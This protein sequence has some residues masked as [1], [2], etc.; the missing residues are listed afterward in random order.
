MRQEVFEL[1]QGMDKN[2]MKTQMALQCAPLITGLKVA[3]LFIVLSE[4][5]QEIRDILDGTDISYMILS[6]SGC[7][8]TFFLYRESQLTAWI[9]RKK[10]RELLQ[11]AGYDGK[12]LADILKEVQI[13]YRAYVREGKRFPHE[14]GLLLGYPPEDVK[15]F[16]VNGGR[17]FL[18]SGYWKVYGNLSETKQLFYRFDLA[19]ESLIE[20]IAK[21]IGIRNVIESCSSNMLLDGAA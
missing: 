5:R 4:K 19:K 15:G 8:T 3:N 21:G 16:V 9:F 12:V 20:L 10:N 2:S 1:V 11:E 6:T 7:K 17:N 14:I 18:Y 13:R